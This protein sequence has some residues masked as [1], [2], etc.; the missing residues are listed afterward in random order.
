MA[1]ITVRVI[2]GSPSMINFSGWPEK[3]TLSRCPVGDAGAEALGLLL[4]VLHQLESVDPLRK[5][6]EVLHNT[7]GGEKAARLGA[8]EDER[9]EIRARGV[10]GRG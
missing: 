6:G 8:G 4:Q 1:T 7:R 2:T 3:S 10:N 5:T 9:R